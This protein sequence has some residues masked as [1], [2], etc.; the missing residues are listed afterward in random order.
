MRSDLSE[1]PSM[2][3]GIVSW[4]RS[5][6]SLPP[7][8]RELTARKTLD[9]L[10]DEDLEAIAYDWHTWARPEQRPPEGDWH[11]WL[12]QA[13]RGSGKTRS[14]AEWFHSR[15]IDEQRRYRRGAMVAPTPAD[16]RDFMIEGDSGL[17]H[18]GHPEDRP[19]YEPSKRRLTWPSGFEAL[20]YSAEDPDQIR[21][22]NVDTAW[23]S[24]VGAW[25]RL[26]AEA[27]WDN[28]EFTLRIGP[29]PRVVVDTT[30]RRGSKLLQAIREDA[31]TVLTRSSTYANAANL[32][33]QFLETV[34]RKYEGTAIGRQELEGLEIEEAEGALWRYAWIRQTN[35]WPKDMALVAIGVDPSGSITGD[36]TGI[37]AAGT[38]SKRQRGWALSDYSGK[39]SPDQWAYRAI[40]L[41]AELDADAIVVER[42]FGGDMCRSTLEKQLQL[43]RLAP[44]ESRFSDHVLAVLKRRRPI[45]ADV[46][47][48]RGKRIRAEPVAM[49][50]EQGAR[51]EH[52]AGLDQLEAEMTGWDATDGSPS[53][54]RLDAFV[55][56]VTY[57]MLGARGEFSAGKLL[58]V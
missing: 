17:L 40:S 24:E 54:N 42:N 31:G 28:L 11:V 43:A 15:A 6:A 44:E 47:A 53:P 55:W 21:G 27:A 52:M 37:V 57:L 58:G 20:V 30:P 3:Q 7:A 33:M 22:P 35:A 48:S 10:T 51:M 4:A 1:L 56:A 5:L 34:L 50:Y 36:E 14:A 25:P 23:A 41:W 38:D 49:L 26:K 39:W 2:R 8:E 45:I 16:A 19:H 12:F 18:V 46:T 32:S 13:G 9:Q 29:D